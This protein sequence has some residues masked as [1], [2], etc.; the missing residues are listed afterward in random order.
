MA[1][2]GLP[3][4]SAGFDKVCYVVNLLTGAW[5]P[6]TGWD[7]S[8]SATMNG[9]AYFGTSTGT[10]QTA[11]AGGSDDGAPYF[12]TYVGLFDHLKKPGIDKT[13]KM[14]RATFKF[15]RP[16]NPRM[17]ASF[18]YVPRLPAYPDAATHPT[19]GDE[20]DVGLW[21]VALWDSSVA[22]QLITRWVS[23][24]GHGFTVAPNLQITNNHAA[25]PLCELVSMDL[26]YE[27]GAIVV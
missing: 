1:I 6:Y 11:E 20:W 13:A 7:V 16:F 8:C 22:E 2:V 26:L 19:T 24:Y 4:P 5:A 18:N 21:D 9:L 23:V 25:A 15:T 14:M 3:Y 12:S 17:S 10:V 27:D